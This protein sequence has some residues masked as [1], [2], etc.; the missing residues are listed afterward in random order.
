MRVDPGHPRAAPPHAAASPN[1]RPSTLGSEFGLPSLDLEA[2][3]PT[4]LPS[5]V[6]DAELAQRHNALPLAQ[7]RGR[8]AVA[9]ADPANLAALNEIKL[10][11]GCDTDAVLVAPEALASALARLQHGRTTSLLAGLDGDEGGAILPRAAGEAVDEAPI[12]KYIDKVLR[13]AVAAGASDIHFEPYDGFYRVRLRVDGVLRQ[14]ERPPAHLGARFASRLKVMAQLDITERRRPQDGRITLAGGEAG[15]GGV[16]LRVST[17]PTM[18]GEKV[19]L[20]VLDS[21]SARMAVDQLGLDEAQT[22][23][24]VNALAQ[25]QGMILVTGPTGSG[26]TVSLYA[27]LNRLNAEDRNIATAEDPVEIDVPGIN[28]VQVNNRAGLDFETALRAF[29]RQD[30]DV[31]MVGEIRD[32]ATAEMAIKAAQTGHLVLSTLHTGSAAET[33]TR[34]RNMGVPAFNIASSVTLLIAQ[35]LAR[36][37]CPHCRQPAHIPPEAML[38]QGFTER[39]IAGGAQLFEA[40]DA[41]CGQCDRGYRGRTGIHEVVD[42]SPRLQRLI[43]AGESSVALANAMRELGYADLRRSGLAKVLRGLTSLREINRVT[44]NPGADAGVGT[45]RATGATTDDNDATDL[46]LG[47][48]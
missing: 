3:D 24:Y 17:L 18:H 9:I 33:L 22:R 8:L 29:L 7:R 38:E 20:R 4:F 27:G 21:A 36:L 1:H 19:V 11:T 28:Q 26:K 10:R 45:T 35:R 13:D 32:R 46:P 47:R 48:C 2:V 6:M 25:P 41:G 16:D 40:N 34:L 39:D 15:R 31:L 37:L 44:A 12:V 5:G 43:L 30:P 42:V 23:R 14:T